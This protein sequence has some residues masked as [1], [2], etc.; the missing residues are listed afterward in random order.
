[1][2]QEKLAA[3]GLEIEA[4]SDLVDL[5][6]DDCGSPLV[7]ECWVVRATD[8]NGSRWELSAFGPV[9]HRVVVD[10]DGGRGLVA[11]DAAARAKAMADR[12]RAAEAIDLRYWIEVQPAYG[13]PA[14]VVGGWEAM[15]RAAEREEEGFA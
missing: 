4:V 9:S 5:G 14:Y 10:S 2:T 8:A 3:A 7:G 11:T 1:M 13:S 6:L 12:V 15:I